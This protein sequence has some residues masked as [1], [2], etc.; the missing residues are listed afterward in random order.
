[1]AVMS[2]V[3]Q[4][5]ALKQQIWRP[6]PCKAFSCEIRHSCVIRMFFTDQPFCTVLT[7]A[8]SG[9]EPQG[10]MLPRFETVQLSSVFF[11]CVCVCVRVRVRVRVRVCVCALQIAGPAE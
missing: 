3:G 9:L 10:Y 11:V 5:R 6:C 4:Q 1:M 2:S 8:G 7:V